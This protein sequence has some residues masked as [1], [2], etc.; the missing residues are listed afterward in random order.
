MSI[1]VREPVTRALE[2]NLEV[3]AT[4]KF[5]DPSAQLFGEDSAL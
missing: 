4:V 2:K 3:K 1:W 5:T